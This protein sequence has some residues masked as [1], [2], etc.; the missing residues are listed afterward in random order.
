MTDQTRKADPV[1]WE[2]AFL[3][4]TDAESLVADPTLPPELFNKAVRSALRARDK[5]L[6]TR[7]PNLDAVLKKLNAVWEDDLNGDTALSMGKCSIIGNL[8]GI[9]LQLE[10][11]TS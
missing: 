5:M 10:D 2:Q 1:A 7:A 3:K 4:Y 11:L 8:R 6:A 9:M